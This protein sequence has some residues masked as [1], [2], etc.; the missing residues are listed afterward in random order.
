MPMRSS[1][2]PLPDY[3]RNM[4]IIAG[5]E[6]KFDRRSR[7]GGLVISD[8]A[9]RITR[10]THGF[11]TWIRCTDMAMA[12]EK[13]ETVSHEELINIVLLHCN[14]SSVNSSP[15]LQL[16]SLQSL[17]RS[18]IH[19]CLYIYTRSIPDRYGSL[20]SAVAM[21][22]NVPLQGPLFGLPMAMR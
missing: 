20:L 17:F 15:S 1:P 19:P 5:G 6:F 22:L 2:S 16:Q 3:Y 13:Q 10:F 7:T 8:M 12:K 18:P 9:Y 11:G 21:G 14:G 4:I